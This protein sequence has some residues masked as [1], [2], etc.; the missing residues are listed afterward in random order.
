MRSVIKTVQF[1]INMPPRRRRRRQRK[2]HTFTA[3]DELFH[4][5]LSL[6][7]PQ[8]ISRFYSS[9]RIRYCAGTD[10]RLLYVIRI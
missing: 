5:L 1:D 7:R 8:R 3:V 10:A 2:S 4:S 6:F 9:P